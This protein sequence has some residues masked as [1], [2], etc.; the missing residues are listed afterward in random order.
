MMFSSLI[1]YWKLELLAKR[2]R[3]QSRNCVK[4]I[5]N[6]LSISFPRGGGEVNLVPSFWGSADSYLS[7]ELDS[8][9]AESNQYVLRDEYMW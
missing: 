4:D 7:S 9:Q 3:I 1:Q 8:I 5:S 2:G 6:F